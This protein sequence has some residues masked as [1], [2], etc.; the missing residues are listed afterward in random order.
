MENGAS[1]AGVIDIPESFCDIHESFMDIYLSSQLAPFSIDVPWDI[2]GNIPM[3]VRASK[4][5]EK[6]H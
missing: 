5:K 3:L 6:K 2:P 4:I 1:L